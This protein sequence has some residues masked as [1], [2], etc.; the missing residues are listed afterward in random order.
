MCTLFF[1][2]V[3]RNL[4]WLFFITSSQ[5]QL[6]C[7][8]SCLSYVFRASVGVKVGEKFQSTKISSRGRKKKKRKATGSLV[9][10]VMKNNPAK[11]RFTTNSKKPGCKSL[12]KVSSACRWNQLVLETRACHGP[13]RAETFENLMDR[14]GPRPILLKFDAPGRAAAHPLEIWWAGPGRGP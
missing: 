7:R 1:R 13:G 2:V 14:A 10:I 4:A 3:Q 12:K 9:G 11:F 5:Y 8:W 6:T